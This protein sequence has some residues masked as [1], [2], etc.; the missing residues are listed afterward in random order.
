MQAR[1]LEI[2]FRPRQN[3]ECRLSTVNIV[4]RQSG[5]LRGNLRDVRYLISVITIT[6]GGH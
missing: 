1:N 6:Y 5:I 3:R 2:D 4:H